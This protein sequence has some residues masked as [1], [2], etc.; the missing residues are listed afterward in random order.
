ML[1]DADALILRAIVNGQEVGLIGAETQK[2]INQLIDESSPSTCNDLAETREAR[3][4]LTAMN[5]VDMKCMV[6]KWKDQHG[7]QEI[8]K[9]KSILKS[10]NWEGRKQALFGAI[11]A[12]QK[13]EGFKK[14]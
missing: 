1:L 10:G 14:K 2:K 6:I 13:A 7:D 5:Y 12:I 8:T 3:A 11:L 4:S 9:G